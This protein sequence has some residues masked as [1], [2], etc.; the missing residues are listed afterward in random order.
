MSKPRHITIGDVSIGNDLGLTLI[1]GPCVLESSQHAMDMS[2]AL[3]EMSKSLG[4]GL[5]YKTSYDK[6]NRTSGA[7]VRQS[8]GP[9]RRGIWPAGRAVEIRRRR[10]NGKDP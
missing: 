1:A 10:G 5:I 4:V 8:G 6:A 9:T 7:A 2:G 3:A